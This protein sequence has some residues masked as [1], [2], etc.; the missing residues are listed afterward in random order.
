M[1]YNNLPNVLLITGGRISLVHGTGTT[2]IRHFAGYPQEKL[3]NL[4]NSDY[5]LYEEVEASFS[6]HLLA[7]RDQTKEPPIS[8]RLLR[9]AIKKAR[10]A[11]KKE[12]QWKFRPVYYSPVR[13][14]IEGMGFYPDI[15]YAS[16]YGWD[17]LS[18]LDQVIHEYDCK[19]PVI[20]HFLDYFP[21]MNEE[22]SEEILQKLEPHLTEIWSLT[23][24]VA[25]EVEPIVGREVKVV[26]TFCDDLPLDFKREH[27]D[28]GPDFTAVIFG[29]IW[30]PKD[31]VNDI[32]HAWK[33]IGE[34]LG[35]IPSIQWYGHENSVRVVQSK[36]VQ[37]SP[38]IEYAGFFQGLEAQEKL[39]A[40]DICILPFNRE[41][42]PETDYAKYSLP[43]RITDIASAG[44]PIFLVGGEHSETAQYIKKHKIGVSAAPIDAERFPKCLKDFILDK[45]RRAECGRHARELAERQYDVVK[46]RKFLYQK[47]EEL[48]RQPASSFHL[49]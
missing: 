40:A 38:E 48:A 19:L 2:F 42:Y 10:I 15:I 17:S 41:E 27:R 44:L 14:L 1:V 24:A 26:N 3:F 22:S 32:R 18:L 20:Q 37:L 12:R 30:R 13:P 4:Y 29:N 33:W 7:P 23:H 35:G 34:T 16:C 31:L 6:Q 21:E 36:G 43:S 46:Y 9:F 11:I 8:N 28:F 25:A 45:Q 47:L 39:R 49:K 5:S